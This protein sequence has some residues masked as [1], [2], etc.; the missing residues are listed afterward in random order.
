MSLE[1]PLHARLDAEEKRLRG[2]Q[3][4]LEAE[5]ERVK[6]ALRAMETEKVSVE[7]QLALINKLKRGVDSFDAHIQ[8]PLTPCVS[9]HDWI[10]GLLRANPAGLTQQDI[11]NFVGPRIRTKASSYVKAVRDSLSHLTLGK[12]IQKS[13]DGVYRISDNPLR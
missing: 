6:D 1:P 8:A 4:F 12:R 3:A 7:G 2:R 9:Q 5:C 10:T 11:I 13:E